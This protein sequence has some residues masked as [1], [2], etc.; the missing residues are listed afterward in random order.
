VGPRA[1][2]SQAR[3]APR[4][5]QA[6]AGSDLDFFRRPKPSRPPAT[7]SPYDRTPKNDEQERQHH[8]RVAHE[9]GAVV[10]HGVRQA[11][12][13]L[14][15]SPRVCWCSLS[16]DSS[17]DQSFPR[18]SSSTATE[19]RLTQQPT[20]CD[21]R[22]PLALLRVNRM[23]ATVGPDPGNSRPRTE[24]R[25]SARVAAHPFGLARRGAPC[26]SVARAGTDP[27]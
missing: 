10:A 13:P 9:H 18:T 26:D 23:L 2:E 6:V 25:L 24:R 8:G 20:W 16:P 1:T 27:G 17:C 21:G 11:R 19:L 22:H 3:R 5:A 7:L 14:H 12:G 4:V 15:L